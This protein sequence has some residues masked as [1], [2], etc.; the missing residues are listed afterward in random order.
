MLAT[1]VKNAIPIAVKATHL[2]AAGTSVWSAGGV[3]EV[4][5]P[6]KWRCFVDIYDQ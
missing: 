5:G 6:L 1:I 3:E 2:L 4:L